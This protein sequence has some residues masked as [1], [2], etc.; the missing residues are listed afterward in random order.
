[1]L[2]ILFTTTGFLGLPLLWVNRRFNAA[3]RVIWSVVVTLYTMALI[4]GVVAI[5]VWSLRRI[6]PG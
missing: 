2:A 1:M 5:C 6:T 4:I 3:E